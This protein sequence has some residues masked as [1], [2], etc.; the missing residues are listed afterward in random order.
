MYCEEYDEGCVCVVPLRDSKMKK[1]VSHLPESEQRGRVAEIFIFLRQSAL[2]RSTWVANST[3]QREREA[4]GTRNW[5]YFE[6]EKSPQKKKITKRKF[7]EHE[8]NSAS[9]VLSA[10]ASSAKKSVG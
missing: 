6:R 8:A 9:L 5:N 1:S 7:L 3:Q 4:T 10:V 2:A